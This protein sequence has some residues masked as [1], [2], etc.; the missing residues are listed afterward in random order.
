MKHKQAIKIHEAHVHLNQK[1]LTEK[2]NALNIIRYFRQ[3]M[4]TPISAIMYADKGSE[5]P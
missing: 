4:N 3:S 5:E 2:K 1:V